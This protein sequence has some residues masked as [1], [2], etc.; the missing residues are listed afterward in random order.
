MEEYKVSLLRI[1]SSRF[2]QVWLVWTS[3]TMAS[4]QQIMNQFISGLKNRNEE[5]RLKAANDLYHFVTNEL[6]ELPQAEI[7]F[8]LDDFNHHVFEM[9]SSSDMNE[10]KGGILTIGM[11]L[12]ICGCLFMI[13][14]V[15]DFIGLLLSI[16]GWLFMIYDVYDFI[17]LWVS[18]LSQSLSVSVSSTDLVYVQ[19][20]T[21]LHACVCVTVCLCELVCGCVHILRQFS[22]LGSQNSFEQYPLNG[23]ANLLEVKGYVSMNC[24]IRWAV[25]E[26]TWILFSQKYHVSARN[27]LLLSEQKWY[28]QWYDKSVK[29]IWQERKDRV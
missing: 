12:S 23:F 17:L 4:T 13:Y 20:H 19:V 22:N 18:L 2:F 11:L 14:D 7:T 6:R 29:I 15:Y 5:V 8:F 10:R 28:F 27:K 26:T 21:P 24:K 16:C 9:V 1:C 3:V 25:A